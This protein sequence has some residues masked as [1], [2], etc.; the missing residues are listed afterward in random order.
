VGFL[1]L[2]YKQMSPD[3][4][5]RL[6]EKPENMNPFNYVNVITAYALERLP[7]YGEVLAIAVSR[8]Y[9]ESPYEQR[10]VFDPLH[11]DDQTKAT[12]Y[13]DTDGHLVSVKDANID[14][15]TAAL[16][17][18]IQ[19]MKGYQSYEVLTGPLTGRTFFPRQR[20]LAAPVYKPGVILQWFKT[21]E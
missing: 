8:V 15:T 12:L 19:E 1:D 21:S 2:I 20:P 10:F 16:G 3:H 4:K 13:L 11:S 9:A 17:E 6:L 18:K 7:D 14:R 5:A